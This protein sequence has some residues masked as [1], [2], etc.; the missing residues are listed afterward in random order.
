RQVFGPPNGFG[1]FAVG[2]V[3]EKFADGK[4]ED[5]GEPLGVDAHIEIHPVIDEEELAVSDHTKSRSDDDQ[6]V[7]VDGSIAN[8]ETSGGFSGNVVSHSRHDGIEDAGEWAEERNGK[9]LSFRDAEFTGAGHGA[10]IIAA[11]AE[12]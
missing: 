3:L 6:V 10:G 8:I 7:G 4:Q 2:G 9:H 5:A 1:K 12:A 11:P